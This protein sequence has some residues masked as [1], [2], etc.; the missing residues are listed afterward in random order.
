MIRSIMYS[1]LVFLGLPVEYVIMSGYL[2]AFYQ[3]YLHGIYFDHT[4][5]R[6]CIGN[7]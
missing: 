7:A 6:A 1:S 5:A 2:N 4:L 3:Y